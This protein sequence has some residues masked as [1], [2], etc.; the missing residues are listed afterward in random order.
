MTITQDVQAAKD[1]SPALLF[2]QASG[3]M[4]EVLVAAETLTAERMRGQ[5]YFLTLAG[6]FALTLP[7]P[8]LGLNARFVVATSPTTA[9][10]IATASGAN[11]IVG[12]IN[13]LEV[14]T[15]DDGP[16]SA[17][18]DLISF[19]ANIAVKGDWLSLISDGTSWFLTGQT[20]ADGGITIGS[21]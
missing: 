7:A 5:T 21:T 13:E 18:G 12:G 2:K 10:T 16:Y 8:A 20:N 9:Y 6:G 15:S 4:G 11:L 17:V 19:V 14:D 3:W 1:G